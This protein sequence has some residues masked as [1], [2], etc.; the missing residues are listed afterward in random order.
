VAAFAFAGWQ[1]RARAP[2]L[3]LRLFRS[4]A[5]SA[6]NAAIFFLNASLTGAVS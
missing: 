4:R 3:P 5:F 6:G 1:G 2:M